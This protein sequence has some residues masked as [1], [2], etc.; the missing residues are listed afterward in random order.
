M[1]ALTNQRSSN[2]S[3][4]KHRCF[5]QCELADLNDVITAHNIIPA[6]VT[7]DTLNDLRSSDLWPHVTPSCGSCTWNMVLC[8]CLQTHCMS[9]YEQ[10]NETAVC[11]PS[12]PC[13]WRPFY[14]FKH[15]I[16]CAAFNAVR[17]WL[18]LVTS[19]KGLFNKIFAENI[20]E[21]L[22]YSNVNHFYNLNILFS[23]VLF[24]CIYTAPV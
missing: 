16:G 3:S 9:I 2:E 1:N 15:L 17:W 6:C 24:Y 22:S 11:N 18:N 21:F 4:L 5:V 12:I 14:F 8:L 13:C 10:T 7:G 20:L 19:L 23:L